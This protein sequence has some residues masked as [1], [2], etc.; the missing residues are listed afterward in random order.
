MYT[1]TQFRSSA[2]VLILRLTH[3][4][5]IR[6]LP[7]NNSAPPTMTSTRPRQNTSPVNNFVTPN[8]SVPPVPAATVVAKTAPS[9]MNDPASILSASVRM[10]LMWAF[11]TPT[12]FGPFGDFRR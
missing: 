10:T 3:A 2:R 12:S 9:A 5:T 11:F 4:I 8:G 7:V 6:L 1:S